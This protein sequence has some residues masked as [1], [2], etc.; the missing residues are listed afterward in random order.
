MEEKSLSEKEIN[1]YILRII[2]NDLGIG[3]PEDKLHIAL[4]NMNILDSIHNFLK[5]RQ[6]KTAK[7]IEAVMIMKMK[8]AFGLDVKHY[9]FKSKISN[10]I[11]TVTDIVKNDNGD[12]IVKY[13]LNDNKIERECELSR[14]K[15]KVI[16]K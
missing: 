3:M 1:A 2:N 14:F 4:E 5:L 9:S 10:D 7:E 8:L 15:E 13:N 6:D 11:L 12:V 16:I